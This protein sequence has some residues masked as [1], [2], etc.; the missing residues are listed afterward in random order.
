MPRRGCDVPQILASGRKA[1]LGKASW[2][3]DEGQVEARALVTLVN[4][5][6]IPTPFPPYLPQL[7]FVCCM[8]GLN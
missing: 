7:P 2:R 1:E 8:L 3:C 5:Y 4:N 6:P